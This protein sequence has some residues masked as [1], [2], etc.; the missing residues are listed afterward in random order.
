MTKKQRAEMIH[1]RLAGRYPHPAPALD[2]SNPWE[3][4]VATVLSAQCTDQRVN[5][6]TPELFRRWPGPKDLASIE[7]EA[8]EEV[9]RSTGLFRSKAKNL[10]AAARRVMEVYGGEVPRTMADL[11]TLGGVA[12]KT[13]NIVLSN[14]FHIHE[15][16]AV[17]THVKRLAF[18]MG[19]TASDN[20]V[21]IEKD[22]MA[23][24]PR[25]AWGDVNHELV[26]FGR[27]VCPARA[28]RCPECELNDICPKKGVTTK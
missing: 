1:V 2:H 3:L 12:R 26:F 19:L 20:P 14:A 5:M 27:E 18:R 6:V 9:I 16:I 24:F 11:T 22:L 28:P 7:P 15:G 21:A 25:E 10:V 23:L 8:L 13:A 4:L 17:D